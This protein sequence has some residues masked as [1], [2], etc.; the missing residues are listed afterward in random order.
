[1]FDSVRVEEERK[2][3]KALAVARSWSKN[4][5]ARASSGFGLILLGMTSLG[6]SYVY[7]IAGPSRCEVLQPTDMT[8][9][10]LKQVKRKVTDYEANPNGEIHLDGSEASFILA[11]NLKYPVKIS[12]DG[13]EMVASLL[14]RADQQERCYN[15][16]FTGS[17][18][19]EDGNATVV[20]SQLMVGG[21]NLSWLFGGRTFHI[22]PE[23][24]G[25]GAAGQMLEQTETLRLED[26]QLHI[27]LEDP[28]RLR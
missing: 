9:D 18:A 17:V 22:D 27:D 19:V 24:V 28:R 23:V 3:D 5:Y 10:Q 12:V 2:R 21:L 11:D 25:K 16:Q 26:S 4:R 15:V 14:I 13:E 7:L 8:M 6:A 1:V 20:P